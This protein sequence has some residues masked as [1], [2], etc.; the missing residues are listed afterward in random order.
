[1]SYQLIDMT[2]DPR[3]GQFAY[4]R[5]ML[6][7]FAGVT[8]EV[9]ITDFAA[10]R[11]G[12]L[13]FLSFLYAVVRAANA[14]PQLRRR[15]TEDGAVVEYDWC[16]PSYTAMKPDGVYVY[17]TVEGDLPYDEF[18]RLGQSR[19]REV[20][21][22]G[23]LTE[24]GDVRGMIFVSSVPWLHY[25]QLQHPAESP[26]DSNPRISWGKYVTVNGRTTLPVS[27]FVSH[28]YY[29]AVYDNLVEPKT[30]AKVQEKIA[31]A[32]GVDTFMAALQEKMQALPQALQ[33][34]FDFAALK[35]G[36]AKTAADFVMQQLVEPVACLLVK[37]ALFLLSFII[38]A[39]ICWLLS[40][41][42]RK[43]QGKKTIFTQTNSLLGGAFGLVKGCLFLVLV[44]GVWAYLAG[45]N[46]LPKDNGVYAFFAD[47]A[48]LEYMET[49]LP[50]L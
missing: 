28:Q 47:S 46:W 13:F 23:T 19:Q 17:C 42:L 31:G 10:R 50:T 26:D 2:K 8:A 21:E 32:S 33:G 4:F 25:T 9:D 38:I 37:I 41:M 49:L 35:K 15:I 29:Q 36:S 34:D 12:R 7:P 40:A 3:S 48:I 16:A 1:M 43:K 45:N 30:L 5:Q 6:F 22:R 44:S 24:Y 11:Q 20:L 18:V 27:L 39:L 14:V